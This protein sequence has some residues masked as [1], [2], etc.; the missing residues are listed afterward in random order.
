M[1]QASSEKRNQ[2]ETAIT[3]EE[4]RSS[5]DRNAKR[6]TDN[7]KPVGHNLLRSNTGWFAASDCTRRR[8]TY[9]IPPRH[10]PLI[11]FRGSIPHVGQRLANVK[12]PS[13]P[14]VTRYLGSDC[15]FWPFDCRRWVAWRVWQQDSGGLIGVFL[16]LLLILSL[17]S[18][19]LLLY[20][21]VLV[22]P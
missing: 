6:T 16:W 18:G 4:E 21:I 11:A 17:W 5:G 12:G 20:R 14:P 8:A 13:S 3:S 2:R 7:N 19:S 22:Y 10:T 9:W 1:S 15:S